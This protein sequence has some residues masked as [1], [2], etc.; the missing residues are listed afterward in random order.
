MRVVI[1]APAEADLEQIGDYIAGDSPDRAISFSREL[2]NRCEG[3]SEH[4]NRYPLVHRS[5]NNS[6]RKCTFRSY[7]ISCRVREDRVEVLHILNGAMDYEAI[8][9]PKN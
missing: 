8:L 6:V 7:L 4:P 1:T 5:G 3:L 9:F 2:R